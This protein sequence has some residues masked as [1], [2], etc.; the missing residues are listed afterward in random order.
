MNDEYMDK[1]FSAKDN[2]LTPR[3]DA[4]I[5]SHLMSSTLVIR[6][7]NILDHIICFLTN[8]IRAQVA[9]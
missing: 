4:R 7:I 6:E 5:S 9:E 2:G 8:R 1:A 3:K